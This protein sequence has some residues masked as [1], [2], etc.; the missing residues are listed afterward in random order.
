M[1]ES[2]ECCICHGLGQ[3]IITDYVD[4]QLRREW[5]LRCPRCMGTG[6]VPAIQDRVWE[7]A[8]AGEL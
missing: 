3:I 5:P 8:H 4:F 7:A 6:L 2:K 1:N